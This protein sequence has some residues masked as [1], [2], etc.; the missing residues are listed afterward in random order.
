MIPDAAILPTLPTQPSAG[1][2]PIPTASRV[3]PRRS[4]PTTPSPSATAQRQAAISPGPLA[5]RGSHRPL[6]P[7]FPALSK[8]ASP[9]D[10]R[11]VCDKPP[12]L[13]I[14]IHRAPCR[15][16]C[17]SRDSARSHIGARPGHARG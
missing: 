1:A 6:W 4:S 9:N 3:P 8:P 11:T 10:T 2:Y 13:P 12:P 16:P 7:V 17:L 5:A 15:R 14:P